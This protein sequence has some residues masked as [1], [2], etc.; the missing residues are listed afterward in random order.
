MDAETGRGV[1]G[2]LAST[3][4]AVRA[5]VG[6]AYA[7][8]VKSM[9][10]R[11]TDGGEEEWRGRADAV[12]SMSS[13]RPGACLSLCSLRC[14]TVRGVACCA[15]P[16]CTVVGRQ[17]QQGTVGQTE[18][19]GQMQIAVEVETTQKSGSRCSRTIVSASP[20]VE[21]RNRKLQ[22]RSHHQDQIRRRLSRVSAETLIFGS[23]DPASFFW[24]YQR[25]FC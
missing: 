13:L 21:L 8:G 6:S 14:P 12:V 16:L 2:E 24:L 19:N 5:A 23:I 18:V 1:R 11:R 7:A 17:L 4:E 10:R 20:I 25:L 3:R 9:A 15:Y 22:L